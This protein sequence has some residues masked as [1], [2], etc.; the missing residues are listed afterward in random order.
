MEAATV[1]IAMAVGVTIP[2]IFFRPR[3]EKYQRQQ[4]EKLLLQRYDR[5]N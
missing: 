1:V 3:L 2:T 5:E 4:M